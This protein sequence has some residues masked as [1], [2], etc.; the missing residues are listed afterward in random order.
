MYFIEY[1]VVCVSNVSNVMKMLINIINKI[2]QVIRYL[3]LK[4]KCLRVNYGNL[5]RKF[6]YNKINEILQVL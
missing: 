5:S 6:Y 2:L 1:I 3:F 4:Y